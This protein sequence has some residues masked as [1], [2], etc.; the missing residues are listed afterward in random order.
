M[1][2]VFALM[3]SVASA[4][5]YLFAQSVKINANVFLVY[6]GWFIVIFLLPFL[7]LYPAVFP[8]D[9][10]VISLLQGGIIAYTDYLTF[11]I[12]KNYGS[13]TVSSIIPCSVIIAF[14]MWFLIEPAIITYYTE[15]PVKSILILLSL[16]GAV[17]A[18]L[19]YRQTTLTRKAFFLLLPVLFL[20]AGNSVLNKTIMSYSNENQLICACWRSFLIGLAIGI[21]HIFV[22]AKKKL[23]IKELFNPNTL[24]KSFIFILLLSMTVSKSLAMYYT[25]NPAYVTCI[26]YL[27]L[28]WIILLSRFIGF[29]KF[30]QSDLQTKRRWEFLFVASVIL[31]IL[32]TH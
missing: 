21:I 31:L 3:A 16:C 32:I 11:T 1:W 26:V 10:Y 24:K 14:F 15:T 30:K 29:F 20:S 9:F 7:C 5:Y 23:P 18:L 2:I 22:Y 28:I 6:R 25:E 17:Y 19:K 4:F 12:N 13:E 8:I 27:S